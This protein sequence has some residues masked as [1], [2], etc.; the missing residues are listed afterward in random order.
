V[1]P[2]QHQT[3]VSEAIGAAV[4]H[5]STPGCDARHG[6]N[7]FDPERIADA[8]RQFPRDDPRNKLAEAVEAFADPIRWKLNDLDLQGDETEFHQLG[9]AIWKDLRPSEAVRL[10]ELLYEAEQRVRGAAVEL[11][12]RQYVDA[13]LTFAAEFPN[14]PRGPVGESPTV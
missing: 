6:R 11:V 1:A 13:A 4:A 12:I 7:A 14:A 3:P 10:L 8:W 2:Q 5:T 9:D